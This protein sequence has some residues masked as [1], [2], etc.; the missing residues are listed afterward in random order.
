MSRIEPVAPACGPWR[1][2]GAGEDIP[3][4]VPVIL[5]LGRLEEEAEHLFHR[6]SSLGVLTRPE[7]AADRLVPWLRR[8]ALVALAAEPGREGALLEA[9]RAL[10]QHHGFV[11]EIRAVGLLAEDR[12]PEMRDAGIDPCGLASLDAATPS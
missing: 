6:R 9:A 1:L 4:G 11:G 2:I 5:D 7:E 10:R 8:L 3:A 12:L